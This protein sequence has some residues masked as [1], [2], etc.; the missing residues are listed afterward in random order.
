MP[1][2]WLATAVGLIAF[3]LNVIPAIFTLNMVDA[4]KIDS[5]SLDWK[6]GTIVLEGGWMFA[7]NVLGFNLG[8]FAYIGTGNSSSTAHET[9]HTLSNAAFGSIFHFI[10]AIDENLIQS[11]PHDAYSEVIAESHDPNTNDP[12]IIPMWV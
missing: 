3:V 2:S 7:P 4:V 1:M 10:G 6:T 11:D 9:G 5:L 12:D 8:N